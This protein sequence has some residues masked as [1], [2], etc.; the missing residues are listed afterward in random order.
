MKKKIL[1]LMMVLFGLTT[2]SCN[3]GEEINPDYNYM[4]N[5]GDCAAASPGEISIWQCAKQYHENGAAWDPNDPTYSTGSNP[6]TIAID[7]INN[8]D[9]SYVF[10][11]TLVFTLNR[12]EKRDSLVEGELVTEW[13]LWADY[14]GFGSLLDDN[15]I[16]VFFSTTNSTAGCTDDQICANVHLELNGLSNNAQDA[17]E[18][19]TPWVYNFSKETICTVPRSN[20]VLYKIGV[21]IGAHNVYI[22]PPQTGNGG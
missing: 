9:G 21:L 1:F 18:I 5:E 15:V 4:H 2:M 3:K 22:N 19:N 14:A 11:Y 20:G 16:H 6:S 7:P 10:D 17:Y 8:E 13:H 12:W